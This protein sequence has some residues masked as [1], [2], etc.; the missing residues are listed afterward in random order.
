MRHNIEQCNELKFI[1]SLHNAYKA[2]LNSQLHSGNM[3][4]ALFFTKLNKSKEVR[5]SIILETSLKYR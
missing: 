2:Y 5:D 4:K 1:N 3:S